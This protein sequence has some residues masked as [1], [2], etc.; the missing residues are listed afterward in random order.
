MIAQK[1]NVQIDGVEINR[2]AYEQA[3]ENFKISPWSKNLKALHGDARNSV[4]KKYDLIISNPP[5]YERD[6]KSGNEDKNIAK[7][8]DGLNLDELI[9]I[10]KNDI[11]DK[12][13][14]S[15]LLPF[16]RAE[17]FKNIVENNGL[18]INEELLIKQTP[19]HNYFRAIFLVSADAIKTISST[20]VIK[21][22]NHNYT[23]EFIALLRD[24]YLNL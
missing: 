13:Y 10:V 3:K 5:F 24:Y 17:H 23:P 9:T 2:N 15:L 8:D 1:N 21:D 16:H 6:L 20:L 14:F 12:G 7:H 19:H 11:A 22:A 18:Y 4:I